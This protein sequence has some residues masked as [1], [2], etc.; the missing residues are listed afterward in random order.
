[1]PDD[2]F[3]EFVLDPLGA[4]PEL[5]ARAMFGAHGLYAGDRFFG[6]LDEG[7]LFFKTDAVSAADYTAR[8]MGA[9]T[10]ESKGKVLTMAYHE[11]PP[12]VLENA[13]ELVEWARRAIQIAAT[14]PKT[15]K[16][17]VRRGS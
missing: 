17:S 11:V 9:F 12:D 7:R 6:I 8:G 15:K 10:Y 13:P 3:K 16:K 5:R 2:T 14:K 1:M 4:L